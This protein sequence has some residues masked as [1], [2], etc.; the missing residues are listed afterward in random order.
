MLLLAALLVLQDSASSAYL[1]VAARDLVT[2]A[3]ARRAAVD[4]SIRGYD[5][6]VTERIAVGIRALR[7]DRTLYHRE[8][9]VRVGWRRDTVGR[10]DVL[11]ARQAAPVAGLDAE[12]PD[13]LRS[14]VAHLAFNPA[15]DRLVLGLDDSSVVRHPLAPGSEADYRFQ[16]GDTTTIAFPDGRTIRLLELRV[17]PRR[18]EFR[19]MAGSVWLD[20]D[21]YSVVRLLFRPARPFDLSVDMRRNGDRD[22]DDDDVPAFLKPVR[23]EVRYVTVDYGLWER[24]WWLPRLLAFEG[25][26]TAGSFLATPLRYD[27][28][29]ADYQVQ[30]DA[31]APSG[32]RQAVATLD[33]DTARARCQRLGDVECRCE[34]AQCIPFV[35]YVPADTA[36][37]LVSA[38]L[39]PPFAGPED[40]VMTEAELRDLGRE[41][42]RLP[43]VPW[44]PQLRPPRWGLVR[45]NSIEGLSLGAR[46]ELDLGRAVV[47]GQVR[48]GTADV[49]VNG[50]LGVTRPGTA[51]RLRLAGYRRLALA[52][53][54]TRALGIGGTLGSLILGRDDG[55][56]YR[57]LGVEITGAPAVTLDQGYTW[58]VYAERQTAARKETDASLPHLFDGD[59]VFADNITAAEADQVGAA[60]TLRAWRRFGT[61]GAALGTDIT[62]SGETGSFAFWRASMTVRGSAPLTDRWV[63]ALEAAAGMSAGTVP[64]QSLWYL[65]APGSLRGYA[66]GT[67]KDEAFWRVRADLATAFPAARVVLFGDAGGV[68]PR[69]DFSAAVT[70]ASAGIGVSL[71]DGLFRVD[72]AR[73]LRSPT[74]WRIEFYADGIL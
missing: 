71:L 34:G 17:I 42:G 56:Y 16:S 23:A 33:P 45:F 9:A 13:D 50:E 37:L 64:V 18:L 68:A 55:D 70:L 27:R 22:D 63:G 72:V 25:V 44:D 4:R 41:L 46:L 1:D 20:G 49:E 53:P 3:R 8:L 69:N 14:S 29:Y 43:P 21:S 65:G 26:A 47:D 15:D 32:P 62:V 39:P 2:R 67:A 54:S 57:T 35:V 48:I 30:G 52:D 60:L 59:H 36:G 5:V 73:A 40:T 24:Q 31:G 11:G 28:V 6:T 12:V 38:R 10:I 51:T 58:R 74:G 66:G 7:R 19:L 61:P